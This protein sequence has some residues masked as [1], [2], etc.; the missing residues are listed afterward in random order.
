[1]NTKDKIFDMVND[2]TKEVAEEMDSLVQDILHLVFEKSNNVKVI[3]SALE[4][5]LGRLTAARIYQGELTETAY[6]RVLESVHSAINYNLE[7]LKRP[8]N[9]EKMN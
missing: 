8:K 7:E 5:S 6:L 9:K 1:M 2:V 4:F 3:T